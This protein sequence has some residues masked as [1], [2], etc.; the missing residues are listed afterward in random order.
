MLKCFPH[1]SRSVMVL[2]LNE[3]MSLKFQR[4]NVQLSLY[5][6]IICDTWAAFCQN[7]EIAIRKLTYISFQPCFT[8]W[9]RG[10][11]GERMLTERLLACMKSLRWGSRTNN[12]LWANITKVPLT[13]CWTEKLPGVNDC[14]HLSPNSVRRINISHLKG[15][16]CVVK[17]R[18]HKG[19]FWIIC[20]LKANR[21][22][23]PL[24][25]AVKHTAHHR[26]IKV[27]TNRAFDVN[28]AVRSCQL[29]T[30]TYLLSISHNEMQ[31][32]EICI[33]HAKP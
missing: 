6:L 13:V 19:A 32:R 20:R 30:V 15:A 25:V 22:T 14:V 8:V 26:F 17:L 4:F 21:L 7:V 12:T 18:R 1:L 16:A 31:I 23:A 11:R 3:W 5:K 10:D 2:N 29:C 28:T 9:V 33:R 27:G 24:S